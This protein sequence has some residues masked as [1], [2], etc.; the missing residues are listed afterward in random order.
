MQCR[1]ACFVG[2]FLR[3]RSFFFGLQDLFGFFGGSCNGSDPR[4]EDSIQ[5]VAKVILSLI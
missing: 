1:G 3:F 2:L 5:T 4:Q